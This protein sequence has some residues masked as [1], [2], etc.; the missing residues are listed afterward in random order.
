[1]KS[2]RDFFLDDGTYEALRREY[3]QY[4]LRYGKKSWDDFFKWL[5]EIAGSVLML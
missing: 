4:Q 1:M 3:L 2:R 5:E